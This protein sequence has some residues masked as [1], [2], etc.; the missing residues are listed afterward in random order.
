MSQTRGFHSPRYRYDTYTITAHGGLWSFI[1]R[2]A[3]C[4]SKTFKE[5]SS[6]SRMFLECSSYVPLMFLLCSSHVARML[7]ECSSN[8]PRM[9]P[10]QCELL[11]E[12]SSNV[13]RMLLECSSHVARMLLEC[14]SNVP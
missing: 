3:L 10:E 6:T 8:V 1:T 11:L 7:L 5:H 14:C 12:C 13:P 4:S 9:F 2:L